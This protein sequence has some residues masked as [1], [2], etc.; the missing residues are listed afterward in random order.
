[1]IRLELMRKLRL[2]RR[3][4][5]KFTGVKT[6]TAKIFQQVS[7]TFLIKSD[8]MGKSWKLKLANKV[9]LCFISESNSTKMQKPP[10]KRKLEVKC[11]CKM[12]P[13]ILL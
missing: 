2:L 10:L 11:C 3:A 12:L 9:I 13:S 7:S 8:M 1:M 5:L 6:S 4:T